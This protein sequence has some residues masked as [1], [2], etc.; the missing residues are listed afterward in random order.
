MLGCIDPG[1][2]VVKHLVGH[3]RQDVGTDTDVDEAGSRDL[4]RLAQIRDVDAGDEV[5]S[6]VTRR[7][8]LILGKPEGG[9]GLEVTELRLG[10]GPQLRV[11]PRGGLEAFREHSDQ[12][13]HRHIVPQAS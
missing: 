12:R 13:Q 1:G 10:R 5:C 8:P 4:Q 11:G 7:A 6:D 9:I 2:L 3:A